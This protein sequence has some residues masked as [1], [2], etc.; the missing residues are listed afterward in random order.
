VSKSILRA[1]AYHGRLLGPG[2]RPVAPGAYT[3]RFS[4]HADTRGQRASWTELVDDVQVG[5][6]GWFQAVLGLREPIDPR[7]FE[8]RTRWLAARQM[9]GG[10]MEAE[11]SARA[12]VLGTDLQLVRQVERH[13]DRIDALEELARGIKSGP[14]KERLKGQLEELGR[15]LEKV[16][17]GEL[18]RVSRSLDQLLDRLDAIDD[19][20]GRL[21]KL[22]D[23]LDD[24]DGPDGDII[25]CN[26]RLDEV[27][28]RAVRV[29]ENT[30][31]GADRYEAVMKRLLYLES[32]EPSLRH[33]AAPLTAADVGALSVEGG[34]LT[35]AVTI[36]K[37]GLSVE[38][39]DITGNQLRVFSVAASKALRAPR[40]VAEEQLEIRGEITADNTQRCI[41]MRRIEGRNG[42]AKKDGP[43][44]LNTRGGFEVVVG[45]AESSQGMKVHGELSCA[46][47]KTSGKDLAEGFDGAL[48]EP[49]SLVRMDGGRSVVLSDRAYDTRVVGIVSTRPGLQLGSGAV[50]VALRGTAP[51][52]V[53]G[54]VRIGDL[55]VPSDVPGHAMA[56]EP[57]ASH[58]CLVGK[59]MESL[60]SGSG[61]VLALVL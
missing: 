8:G 43:L 28:R 19:E 54:P 49:G 31:H 56:A 33:E 23:R 40:I 14:S 41:Q 48:V 21:D 26:L 42:S 6:D 59:A 3:V 61:L 5:E 36:L 11:H 45:N 55:L 57:G 4:L 51:C 44:Y 29:L 10:S 58:G 35:G 46:E 39:G 13:E 52:K 50:Q 22:E 1:L 25:D 15:R 47:V 32:R 17:I 2:G 34:E 9:V 60:E 18:G 38:S 27:E 12:A 37:G 20:D 53:V 24:L 30:E 7:M 16:E